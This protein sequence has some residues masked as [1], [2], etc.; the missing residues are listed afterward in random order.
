MAL[1][2]DGTVVSWGSNDRGQLGDGTRAFRSGA[3]LVAG[4]ANIVD[5]SAGE[6]HSYALSADGTIWSWGR[7]DLGQLGVGSAYDSW[8]PIQVQSL[9]GVVSIK[10]GYNHGLA[11][12]SDGTIWTWGSN[13]DDR[14]GLRALPS[15]PYEKFES[16]I[17]IPGLSGV[18]GIAAGDS[19]SAALTGDSKVW[20]WGSVAG[21]RPTQLSGLTDVV[22]MAAGQYHLLF[23]TSDG[24]V[25][26]WGAGHKGQLGFGGTVTRLEPVQA[27]GP[28][29]CIAVIAGAVHSM[30]L[31]RDGSLWVW[32]DNSLHQLGD[33]SPGNRL[34]P[35]RRA[36][37]ASV[38]SMVT[39]HHHSFAVDQSGGVLGWGSNEFGQLGNGRSGIQTLPVS[40]D[41]LPRMTSMAAGGWPGSSGRILAIDASAN[42][43]AW[44]SN[45]WGA[46]GDGSKIDRLHPVKLTSLTTSGE[47][48]AV[49]TGEH[50]SIALRRDGSVATWGLNSSDQLG[51]HLGGSAVGTPHRTVPG[52]SHHVRGVAIAA[53]RGHTL[54]KTADGRVWVWGYISKL[55]R[56]RSPV[57]LDSWSVAKKI[58]TDSTAGLNLV[59]CVTRFAHYAE[60]CGR[61]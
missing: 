44:G 26:A 40:P 6:S 17:Q 49:D 48:V 13:R 9:T 55:S 24:L 42:I 14:L 41:G 38:Q 16:P 59:V 5:I 46:L 56:T 43:W 54:L 58:D 12:R 11:L 21:G 27:V 36:G 37:M 51:V 33:S 18:M 15:Y 57:S 20:I 7:N 19:Y 23:L 28:T 52:L 1:R 25:W 47:T 10:A 32:G 53:G 61:V 4:L 29:D 2:A 30:A 39:G 8:T 34:V 35:L 45:E 3:V 50:H 22:A 31:T 60:P